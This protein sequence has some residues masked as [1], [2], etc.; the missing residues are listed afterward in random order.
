MHTSTTE[1]V[2]QWPHFDVFPSLRNDY[3][4]IFELEQSRTP[5]KLRSGP[6]TVYPY[7]TAEQIE[8]TLESFQHNV[9]FWYPT[10]SRNQLDKAR[11]MAK[12]LNAGIPEENS[13]EAC[14]AHLTMALGCASQTIA[15][16]AS[17]TLPSEEEL[18]R[19]AKLREMGDLYFETALK[20]LHVVHMDVGSTATQCLFFTA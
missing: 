8:A 16:L 14:L 5:L 1:S 18:M 13:I 12:M 17:G 10:M 19:R 3:V 11:L 2:L 20:T 6:T 4:S 15:G 7:V 9:N